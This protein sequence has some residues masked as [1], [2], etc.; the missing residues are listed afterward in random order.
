MHNLKYWL[1]T[2]KIKPLLFTDPLYGIFSKT[3]V[4]IKVHFDVVYACIWYIAF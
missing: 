4:Q 3:N 1:I 2:S